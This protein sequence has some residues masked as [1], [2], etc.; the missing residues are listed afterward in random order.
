MGTASITLYDVQ[1]TTLTASATGPTVTGTSASFSVASRRTEG[2]HHPDHAGHPDGGDGLQRDHQ[3][4]RHRRQRLQ[5]HGEHGHE[6]PG[7]QR[8]GQL[9]GTGQRA[10]TYPTSLTFAGGVATASVTLYDAQTTTLT[11]G[12]TGA[13]SGTSGS[14]TV[15]PAGAQT[16]TLSTPSPTAGTAFTE[17]VT[18]KDAYANTATGYTGAKAV[19]FSGPSNA[20]NG[21][22]PTYP[23]SVTFAAG[24]GTA[25]IT[26]TDVQT[27]T[28]TASAT[29]PAVTGTSASFSVA[30][31]CGEGLHHPDHAGH[32]DGGHG[33]QRD[34]QRHRRLRQRL[35]RHR[36]HGHERPG[37]Q[38]PVQLAGTGQHGSLLP[39]LADL[40]RRRGD[41]LGHPL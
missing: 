33:L 14:F 17:T 39:D 7:L 22:A 4:H 27:T 26:L 31:R 24:V 6:R 21:T 10:P 25:S 23:G 15:N 3:R 8:P 18:A 16:F 32:P 13:T 38:R 36:E 34:H 1:T 5:R 19:T 35:Q 11:V 9:A 37:L 29:G 41:G 28:L 2:L 40:H 12:A 30:E 20:P